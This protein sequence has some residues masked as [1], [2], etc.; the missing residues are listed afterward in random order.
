MKAIYLRSYMDNY[1]ASSSTTPTDHDVTRSF[2]FYVTE[3]KAPHTALLLDYP[4]RYAI[5]SVLNPSFSGLASLLGDDS[6]H[7]MLRH[8]YVAYVTSASRARSIH[9]HL[10]SLSTNR[11]EIIRV[12]QHSSK[13]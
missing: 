10:F 6:V 1:L 11:A 4:D 8:P 2:G 3:F 13:A 5:D 7:R 12:M 9:A